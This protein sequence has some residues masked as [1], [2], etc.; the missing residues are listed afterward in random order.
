[1]VVVCEIKCGGRYGLRRGLLGIVD[2]GGLCVVWKWRRLWGEGASEVGLKGRVVGVVVVGVGLGLSL[3]RVGGPVP[4]VCGGT[5]P[6]DL[7]CCDLVL[8]MDLLWCWLLL[9]IVPRGM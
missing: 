5:V 4:I 9:V 8:N 2:G 7:L 1:M 3:G 6:V